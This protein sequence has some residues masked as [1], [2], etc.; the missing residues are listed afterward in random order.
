MQTKDRVAVLTGAGSGIGRAI[1]PRSGRG[2]R[3]EGRE[4]LLSVGRLV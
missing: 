1:K 3:A 2:K 4:R